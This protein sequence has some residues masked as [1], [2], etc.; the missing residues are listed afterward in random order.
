MHV[1]PTKMWIHKTQKMQM[2]FSSKMIP[3]NVC[4]CGLH[5]NR[6][7]M[8]ICLLNVGA[9]GGKIAPTWKRPGAESTFST[10]SL[11]ARQETGS[12]SL[13]AREKTKHK[14]KT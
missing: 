9:N 12:T 4:L 11:A 3:N 14:Q 1:F 2:T 8:R 7:W 6:P 13:P 10:S 5:Y